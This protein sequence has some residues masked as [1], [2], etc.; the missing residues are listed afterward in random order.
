MRGRVV[1]VADGYATYSENGNAARRGACPVRN[2]YGIC[3]VRA[4]H[5]AANRLCCR[6]GHQRIRSAQVIANSKKRKKNQK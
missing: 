3:G 1:K 6:Y 4:E 2:K 5:V